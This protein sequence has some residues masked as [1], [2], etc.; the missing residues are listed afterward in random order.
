M[1]D[2]D[3]IRDL[4]PLYHDKA[5]SPASRATVEAHVGACEACR[6]QLGELEAPAPLPPVNPFLV[7]AQRMR[8][9]KRMLTRRAALAVTAVFCALAV[10]VAGGV[11]LYGAFEKERMVPWD[12]SLLAGAD[13]SAAGAVRLELSLP[14]YARATCLF[15]RVTIDGEERDIAILQLTQSWV[16]KYLDTYVGGPEEVAL[17]PGTGLY[18]SR[19]GQKHDVAYGPEYAPEYWNP[20]WKYGGELSA[21]YYLDWPPLLNYQHATEEFVLDALEQHGALIWEG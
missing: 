8:Q 6:A 13:G 19:G 2:C 18:I 11:T 3:I 21:V 17:G 4:L 14:R 16:R 9:A 15:R 20:A 12:Q 5:C 1:T 7:P 10:F